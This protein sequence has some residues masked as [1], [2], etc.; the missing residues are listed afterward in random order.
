MEPTLSKYHTEWALAFFSQ[1]E[2]QREHIGHCYLS[3]LNDEDMR[4]YDIFNVM[5]HALYYLKQEEEDATKL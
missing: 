1:Q 4:E 5:K 2:N 3:K